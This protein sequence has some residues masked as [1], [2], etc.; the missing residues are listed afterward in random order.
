[1]LVVAG[2]GAGAGALA[3]APGDGLRVTTGGAL[4]VGFGGDATDDTA[5]GLALGV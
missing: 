1:V 2:A 3:A 4:R 5:E